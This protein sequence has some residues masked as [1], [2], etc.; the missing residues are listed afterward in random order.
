[1]AAVTSPRLPWRRAVAVGAGVWLVYISTAGGSLGTGDAV[2]VYE[3]AKAILDR[4]AIDIPA[5]QSLEAWRGPDG[6]WYA[7]FGISQAVFD[8]PFILAGRAAA[9][10]AGG[11]LARGE[12]LP[13]AAVAL[14]STLAAAAAVAGA[15]LIA[16]LH[17]ERE[18]GATLAA[19]AIA[20]GTPLWTYSKFGFNAPLTAAFLTGG[21]A[22]L[23]WSSRA[24]RAR[25][26]AIVAGCA[27]GAAALTR[28][29]MFLAA[30]AAIAWA[31]WARHI[32]PRSTDLAALVMP[33]VG[34]AAIWCTLNWMRFGAPLVS[35][36][37]PTFDLGGWMGFAVS[38][39]GALLLYAPIAIAA[40]G[41][42][43][44]LRSGDGL[45]W[46]VGCTAVV[47]FVFYA[48]LEDWL[49]T[50]SYGPRYLVPLLP[51]AAAPIGRWL[52]GR[53]T[54]ARR[55][56]AWALV[57]ISIFVQLPAVAVDF[58]RAEIAAH[59]PPQSERLYAWQWSPQAITA[60]AAATAIPANVGYVTGSR[61]IPAVIESA[62]QPATAS[63]GDRLAFSL[64]FWWLYLYYLRIWPIG[65]AMLAGGVPALAGL[66][67]LRGAVARA[68]VPRLD[69][70]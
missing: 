22:A 16:W 54:S 43:R 20:F 1:M 65:V 36:H 59:Q 44:G 14:A 57:V 32:R 6:R 40:L 29:E 69:A 15:F 9:R 24:V 68:S 19:I 21:V 42:I 38:P 53:R 70:R 48:A 49:G 51:I 45:A 11:T 66:L 63:L 46:L 61:P 31:T 7:P 35:G 50:R 37:R 58:T 2:A 47:L 34:A 25:P 3:E 41:W 5:S 67:I 39:A 10:V 30:G 28:H 33:I 56:A 18:H 27:F 13:K 52:E 8:L 55:A 12:T 64:D 4:G 17:D 60:Q 23:A 26:A 62:G